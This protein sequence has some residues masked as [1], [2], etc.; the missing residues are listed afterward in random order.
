MVGGG[1]RISLYNL[2][3]F[4]P[5][6]RAISIKQNVCTEEQLCFLVGYHGR[7]WVEAV[8]RTYRYMSTKYCLICGFDIRVPIA[9][10]FTSHQL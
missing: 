9:A 5:M 4:P 1:G 6:P 8:Y 10:H 2:I 3:S 7:R